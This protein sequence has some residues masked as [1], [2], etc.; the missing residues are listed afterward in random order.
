[1][2]RDNFSQLAVMTGRTALRGTVSWETIALRPRPSQSCHPADAIDPLPNVCADEEMLG[3]IV[4]IYDAGYV[5]VVTTTIGCAVSL[6]RP[7]RAISSG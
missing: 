5:F 3:Q 6:P 2:M 4:T 1:M 7:I